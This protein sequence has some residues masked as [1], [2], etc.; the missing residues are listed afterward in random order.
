MEV[1]LLLFTA[2]RT[3]LT[4]Y[5]CVDAVEVVLDVS[6]LL[7]ALIA[8]DLF[9]EKAPSNACQVLNPSPKNRSLPNQ[10]KSD[11]PLNGAK[12]APWGATFIA[13]LITALSYWTS[14]KTAC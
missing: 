12:V 13:A 3:V 10:I 11:I 8:L 2:A 4:S 1:V 9:R 5:A 7:V 6:A 14:F